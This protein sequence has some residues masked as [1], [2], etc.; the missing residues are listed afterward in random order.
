MEVSRRILSVNIWTSGTNGSPL[1][2]VHEN[3]DGI[4]FVALYLWERPSRKR[5]WV[6]KTDKVVYCC[7]KQHTTFTISQF[8]ADNVYYGSYLYSTHPTSDIITKCFFHYTEA[9]Y[10]YS[11]INRQWKHLKYSILVKIESAFII[12][13]MF[14]GNT[15]LYNLIFSRKILLLVNM[16]AETPDNVD[17]IMMTM[18]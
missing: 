6:F 18:Q 3:S 2:I 16:T 5:T 8:E 4:A 17:T 15:F 1:N 12:V 9:P 11:V 10:H 13:N 7:L 14:Q